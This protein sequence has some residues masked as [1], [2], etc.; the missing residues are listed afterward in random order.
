MHAVK[1]PSVRGSREKGL[2]VLFRAA[3]RH[4]GSRS[5]RRG[6]VDRYA[7]STTLSSLAADYLEP[8]SVPTLCCPFFGEHGKADQAGA[9]ANASGALPRGHVPRVPSASASASTAAK[10]A[11]AR[12]RAVRS[13]VVVVDQS[14]RPVDE[15]PL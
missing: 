13:I 1:L 15:G 6:A 5:A 7:A 11:A 8:E 10:G 12:R 4:L 9:G 2:D 3:R 14:M